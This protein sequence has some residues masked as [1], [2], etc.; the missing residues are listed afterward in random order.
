ME[1]A[2]EVLKNDRCVILTHLVVSD[3][4]SEK[5]EKQLEELV[6]NKEEETAAGITGADI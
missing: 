1:A 2:E 5:L 6:K 4:T 3:K